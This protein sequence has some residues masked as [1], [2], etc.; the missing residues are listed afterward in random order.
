M[1]LA[2][3]A[4][5]ALPFRACSHDDAAPKGVVASRDRVALAPFPA[6]CGLAGSRQGDLK[7]AGDDPGLS[8]GCVRAA[9]TA[10]ILHSR[11]LAG[12]SRSAVANAACASG[13]AVLPT[14]L[15]PGSTRAVLNPPRSVKHLV[16][17]AGS[18]RRSG[19]I[20]APRQMPGRPGNPGRKLCQRL[21]RYWPQVLARGTAS[22]LC[23]LRYRS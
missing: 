9:G 14:W 2:H 13:S 10:H 6:S 4:C 19:G 20:A 22:G 8:A 23:L 15:H 11:S 21:S 17:V 18:A 3:P 12:R 7:R 5:G 16:E 1:Q